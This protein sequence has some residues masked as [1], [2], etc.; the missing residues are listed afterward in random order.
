MLPRNTK[1][2]YLLNGKSYMPKFIEDYKMVTATR[3]AEVYGFEHK[4]PDV[5][6]L[7]YTF[8]GKK[9]SV[10]SKNILKRIRYC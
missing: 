9:M 5:F 3:V 7:N 4:R 2:R 10:V 6:F 1:L 8:E